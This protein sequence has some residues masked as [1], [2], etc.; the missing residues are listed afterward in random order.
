MI[1]P[2]LGDYRDLR[3]S[4]AEI[5][6]QEKSLEQCCNSVTWTGGN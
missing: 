1:V 4:H 2:W 5:S 6:S 3:I